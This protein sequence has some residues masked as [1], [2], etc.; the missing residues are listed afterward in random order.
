[1][2]PSVNFNLT[3][4]HQTNITITNFRRTIYICAYVLYNSH[5][6]ISIDNGQIILCIFNFTLH[7]KRSCTTWRQSVLC[8]LM[9]IILVSVCM[10]YN[11]HNRQMIVIQYDNILQ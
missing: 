11:S 9:Y 6:C 3:V 7:F 2:S 4:Q 8:I 5:P 10:N 1:M